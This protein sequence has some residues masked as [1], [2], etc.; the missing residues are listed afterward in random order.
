MDSIGLLRT[1]TIGLV[2][3]LS[4]DARAHRPQT[5]EA[6]WDGL[7]RASTDAP[8]S[9][10][11]VLGLRPLG[12]VRIPAGTF[13]MGAT[14]DQMN[15]AIALCDHEVRTTECHEKPFIAL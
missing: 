15:R 1:P 13:V 10:V 6:W 8:A 11:Q 2:L 12:R 14:P 4:A 3:V 5:A 7:A 9:G